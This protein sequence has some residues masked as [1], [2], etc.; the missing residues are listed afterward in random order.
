[1]SHNIGSVPVLGVPFH[2]G[3]D[4]GDAPSAANLWEK[5]LAHTPAPQGTKFVIL[6]F[7]N[8]SLPADNRLEVDL[9]YDTDVFTGVDGG[10]FWTRPVNVAQ[11]G[12]GTG[13][14]LRYV[15]DGADGGGAFVDRYAR[16][17]SL[18]D[19]EALH[20]SITNS[21]PFLAGGWVE[22]I[23]PHGP[24]DMVPKYDPYWICDKLSPPQWQ[25]VRCAPGDALQRTVARS[26]GMIV[27][28]HAPHDDFLEESIGSCTVTLIDSDLVV[29]AGHC[30]S[31]HPFEVPSSSVTFDY[32]VACDGSVLPAYNA[33]F[34]KV[35][36]LVKY[37]YS[38]GRDYAVLQLRGAPPLPPIPV[39]N[40][41]PAVDEEVF[42][43]HHPNGAVKKT[44]PS[45]IGT[46]T[47]TSTGLSIG[48]DLDVAGGSSGSGLFDSQG[49]IVGVL[50]GSLPCALGYSAMKTMLD[51]PILI[52]DPPTERAV[53]LVV[54]RSGSMSESA[55]DGKVKIE[56]A[57]E[58]AEL[59][60]SMLRASMGNEAGLV[61]FSANAS[62]P[63]DFPL[64]T[65][66]GGSKSDLADLLPGIAPNGRTS[67]GDGLATARDELSGA[68]PPRSILLLTDGMENEPQAIADVGSLGGIEITAIGFGTESNLDGPRLTDLAQTHGGYY[69][70]AGTGL[71][72]RKFFALAF[73]DIF[74]AGALADPEMHLP[75]S[76]QQGRDVEFHVCGEEAVT[77]VVGWD[78]A[79][80]PLLLEV[81]TPNG[82]LVDLG[83]GG[84]ETDSGS[85]WRFARIPLPQAGERDGVW[86]A[87]VRRP[88]QGGTEFPTAVFAVRYFIN[89]IAR[90]GPS[91]RPFAPPR[92]LYTGDVLH[93]KVILQFA[94]ETV[95]RGGEVTL[96]LRRPDASVGTILATHGLG[97][98]RVVA[99]DT[100]PARQATLR[101]IEEGSG[102]PVVS[103]VEETHELSDGAEGSGLFMPAGLFGKRLEEALVVE[104]TYSFHAKARFGLGCTATREVQ[105]AHHVSVGI[106][107]AATPVEAEPS[108]SGPGGDRVR[109]TFTPKDR[110]GN[111]VGPGAG[112]GF[113][114]AP[115]PGCTLVGTLQD[116]GD[117]RYVQVIECDPES[118]GPP[119]VS[120]AQPER[121]P[122]VLTPAVRER[123]F[124]RYAAKL[125][126]GVRS[127]CGCDCASVAPGRYAT[128]ITVYNGGGVPVPIAQ[129]VVP[130]ELAGAV[131]GRWPDTS[132][133]RARARIV[134]G[135]GEATTIDCC[136]LSALLLGATAP[137]ALPMTL[138]VV[139]LESPVEVQVSAAYTVV[140]ADGSSPSI[141][142]E[143]IE[144]QAVRVRE[145][146]PA[147]SLPAVPADAPVRTQPPPRPQDTAKP[148]E[149]DYGGRQR[150]RG[151][152]KKPKKGGA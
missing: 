144:P 80:A 101:A 87:R 136:S 110:F 127:D 54:D 99:G 25:N 49:R 109:V 114:V 36:R 84:I 105:W 137:A 145:A 125:L 29:L 129:H 122:V 52:P 22:P 19:H 57:R 89:V 151:R 60:V 37:R 139:V 32:E 124:F 107:P 121:G 76:L 1:M 77:V 86:K 14:P 97:P 98:P 152:T 38:D 48:V 23:F 135:A 123:R 17:E 74:E 146:R 18:Q 11:V 102:S 78:T 111:H 148:A 75:P 134:L 88:G 9:G 112:D 108:G 51:D 50:A 4:S 120:V 69:K 138:G 130:T 24:G 65:V 93:P 42:G 131:A 85:T 28:V 126:C 31:D 70:R 116:L 140:A 119:G 6:H 118:G 20:D 66:T 71:E 44:S 53:M 62:S 8:V 21:D 67:I 68:V 117:G 104:G 33:V 16:G 30:V 113:A 133:T 2:I 59:F 45:A 64:A 13:V 47:V 79:D 61:S 3:P 90:G 72:L 91:L 56:E 106:D 15:T 82:Q 103:Y 58:A 27:S 96:S 143:T 83:S 35:I 10:E 55:G 46:S 128:A 95:P 142:V 100:I 115:L 132:P 141:D 26:V 7:M 5:S 39:R 94:D 92:R 43:V 149:P 41:F 73:G 63:V 150:R 34:Y 81:R 40:A 12:G 147:P